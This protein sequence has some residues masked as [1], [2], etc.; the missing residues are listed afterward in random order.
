MVVKVVEIRQNFGMFLQ[1]VL[2]ENTDINLKICD[3]ICVIKCLEMFLLQGIYID[4][5][6]YSLILRFSVYLFSTQ[7][8]DKFMLC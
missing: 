5:Y 1:S 6:I 7:R 8:K 2:T 4:N 3:K